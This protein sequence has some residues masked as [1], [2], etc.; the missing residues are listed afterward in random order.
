MAQAVVQFNLDLLYACFLEAGIRFLHALPHIAHRV[1][2]PGDKEDWE[3][4]VHF[5]DIGLSGKESE[6]VQQIGEQ[7]EGGIA[8]AQGVGYVGV[9]IFLAGGDPVE[10][11]TCGGEMPVIRAESELVRPDAEGSFPQAFYFPADDPFS[12]SDD[13]G[14]RMS[15][16][17]KDAAVHSAGEADKMGTGEEGTHGMSEQEIGLIWKGVCGTAAQDFHVVDDGPP[18][19]LLAEVYHRAVFQN[20]LSMSEVVVCDHDEA[21]A[22]QEPC[23]GRIASSVLGYAMRNLYNPH[24]LGVYGCP[25][26]DVDEGIAVTG[27]E[28]IFRYNRHIRNLH[29]L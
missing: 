24:N 16:A 5:S 7:T 13:G 26:I 21:V 12:A 29:S 22:A 28:E 17:A 4:L 1:L 9:H 15:S 6:A 10:T 11:C 18:A 3:S 20:R 14:R 23:E 19:V 25:L 27:R 2:V 8:A